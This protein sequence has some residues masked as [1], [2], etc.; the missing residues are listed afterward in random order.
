MRADAEAAISRGE[1]LP[2]TSEMARS[3]G[4]LGL[5][6][7][8][9]FAASTANINAGVS[10]AMG[11]APGISNNPSTRLGAESVSSK[12]LRKY[13]IGNAV[14][15]G[16]SDS[17]AIEF[18]NGLSE[19]KRR[20]VI[21]ELRKSKSQRAKD[22][23][24]ALRDS[25]KQPRNRALVKN[26]EQLIKHVDYMK[27]HGTTRYAQM[28]RNLRKLRSSKNPMQT[29]SEIAREPDMTEIANMN[30]QQF[31][32]ALNE[33][34]RNGIYK[35][36]TGPRLDRNINRIE[37]QRRDLGLIFK[38]GGIIKAQPGTKFD[39]N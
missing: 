17:E 21:S 11:P 9:E 5:D 34:L 6:S 16:L 15:K 37:Q 2:N 8:N 20:S 36:F 26:V 32:E 18:L 19:N 27:Q 23:L 1:G 39:P 38:K 24:S 7:I 13:I 25:Q 4:K 35:Q 33:A 30:P 14:E 22:I 31:R 3:A 28:A 29:L 12:E 10:K